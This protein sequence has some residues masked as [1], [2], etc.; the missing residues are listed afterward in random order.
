[1]R[2]RWRLLI[3]AAQAWLGRAEQN[4]A[5]L[6]FNTDELFVASRRAKLYV[7]LD[8]EVEL[9]STPLRYEIHHRALRVLVP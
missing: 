6:T 3:I 4:P 1:M 8:G 2:N 5:L 7:S 9:L